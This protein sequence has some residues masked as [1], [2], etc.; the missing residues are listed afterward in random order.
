[1][2]IAPLAASCGQN[3]IPYAGPHREGSVPRP[4]VTGA[5]QAALMSSERDQFHPDSKFESIRKK[6]LTEFGYRESPASG[7]PRTKAGVTRA[8]SDM[9]VEMGVLRYSSG[10]PAFPAFPFDY[11]ND[12]ARLRQLYADH[13]LGEVVNESMPDLDALCALMLHTYR[14]LE[15]GTIPRLEDDPGPSAEQITRFKRERNIGGTPRHYAALF[16]Q[17][18]LS[19]GYTGRLVGM[20]RVDETG[21]VREHQVCEVFIP[22]Y[23]KWVVFDPFSRA[24]YYA[25]N[26]IPQSAL[27]LRDIVFD[28]NYRSVRAFSLAGDLTAV[29]DIKEQLLPNYQYIYI[30]RM[31]DILSR[32]PRNG[33]V[34]WQ[35]LYQA[36]LVW[37]DERSPVADGRF[38][39]LS[40]F[41]D[42][43]NP[44]FPLNGVRYVTHNKADF[45]WMLNYVVLDFKPGTESELECIFNA[46]I[47][48][49]QAFS[50]NGSSSVVSPARAYRLK[51]YDCPGGLFAVRGVNAFGRQGF[52]SYLDFIW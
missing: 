14:F 22:Q 45:Y 2:L 29:P 10:E 13:R 40:C 51:L 20:H 32:S 52:D 41:T 24:T 8:F 18:A 28:R 11:E 25:K 31:N 4:G 5:G 34:S 19:C 12:V 26:G 44:R 46:M 1:M 33:S 16:C 35:E 47:P 30:W 9:A 23:R 6:R 15:G 43:S 3:E 21:M 37:E 42:T 49:F 36:H 7:Y 50:A 48:N 17:L 39:Q 27:E 38:E